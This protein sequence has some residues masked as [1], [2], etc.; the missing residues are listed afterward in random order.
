MATLVLSAVGGAIGGAI[1]GS[2]LGVS[3]AAL[4]Q[5]AGATIGRSIDQKILG[6]GSQAVE[7][8]RVDRLRLTGASEGAPI[9]QVFGRMRVAGQVIWAS[10]FTE[11][12]EE[13]SAGGKGGGPEVKTTS[14]SYSVSLA[15]ALCEGEISHVGRV[16]ADG[17]EIARESLSLSIHYGQED[18]APDPIIEAIEG[19]GTVPCYGGLAYVVLEDFSISTYGNRVPQLSFEVFRPAPEDALDLDVATSIEAV[20]LMPGTGEFAYATEPVYVTRHDGSINAVNVNTPSGAT[21][22]VTSLNGMAG[23]LP[24]CGS[25]S[26]IVSWFGNDLRCGSC[27]VQPKV[28]NPTLDVDGVDWSVAG[29]TR[30]QAGVVPVLEERPVYGGT[31][32]DHTIFGAIRHLNSLS[33]KVVFYPFLLMEQLAGNT[34]PDPYGSEE[35]PVLP[36]RGRITTA[37]APGQA[38]SPDKTAQTRA[39]VEAFFGI[40]AADDFVVAQDQVSYVGGPD[41]G[42]RRFILHYAHLCAAA[43]GVDAFCI[44]SEM[45]GLTALRDDLG[46]PAVA[47]FKQLAADVR[48]ILGPDTKIGYAADWSEYFG[49]QP[50]DGSGDRYF[51]LDPL[52]SDPNID[53]I[54]IDNYMPLSDWREGT[55]HLD[56]G[57]KSIY[58]LD[59]LKSNIEGGEGFDWFYHSEEARAAQIRTPIT[60]GAHNEPW[61]YR[62]KDMRSFWEEEHFDR[63]NGQ[64]SATPTGWVP[65]S[66]PIWFTELGCPAVDKGTNQPNKFI[67]PKSS[68]SSLPFFSNGRRDELMQAQYLKAVS[69]YWRDPANN[70]VSELYGGSMIDMTRAHVWAWDAR[71]FPFFPNAIDTWSDGENYARGHWLNGRSSGRDLGSVIKEIVISAGLGAPDTSK[72]YGFVRG[73][74]VPDA[75]TPREALQPLLTA[76]AVDAIEK[77]GILTFKSR[78]GLCDAVIDSGES[79]L[80]NNEISLARLRDNEA[81]VVGRIKLDFVEADGDYTV[82]SSEAIW[83][84]E[85]VQVVSR[86]EV[87]LSLTGGEAQAIAERWL[88]EARVAQDSV[89]ATLPPSSLQIGAGDLIRFD[90]E[91]DV[92]RIDAVEDF[93]MRRVRATRQDPESLKPSREIEVAAHVANFAVSVPM[94]AHFLDLPS[95]DGLATAPQMHVAL[96]SD[97]W[98]GQGAI[99]A[100]ANGSNLQLETVAQAR[101]VTGTLVSPLVQHCSGRLQAGSVDVRLKHGN[102]QSLEDATFLAGGNLAALGDGTASAWE[103]VQFQ[104]AEL[105]APQ[106]YRLSGLLR[107]QGGSEP[108]MAQVWPAGTEFIFL[109]DR[110]S[111][112]EISIAHL[113]LSR[114]FAWGPASETIS[115]ASFRDRDVV[116]S[117]RA[118]R[119]YAPCH[120]RVE[121]TSQGERLT[122]IRRSR[123]VGEFWDEIETPLGEQS[124]RY[125]LELSF[126]GTLVRKVDLTESSFLYDASMQ[127][128]DGVT[129]AFD[130]RV[131]QVSDIYGPGA[132][133]YKTV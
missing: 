14:Y 18:Q 1:G 47:A 131:A 15:V 128:A 68:E 118:L 53:F 103:I 133:A 114:Q 55:A 2:V 52:W 6:S 117:G 78:N 104:S 72:A 10:R 62:Y 8:G 123:V 130:F 90:D 98:P 44:G 97:P 33:Q 28:E 46:F 116:V 88:S 12:K 30:A 100:S 95:L 23:E 77:D 89:Q 105:I 65:R 101:S 63:V 110:L 121:N 93:G 34:L 31:P 42:Y 82:R 51:H 126:G 64:R 5:L 54:G 40:A 85:T 87:N 9:G 36:W 57:A 20:A 113:R 16:W 73:F 59:Y 13:S 127:A 41:Q 84:D 69:S 45:R 17:V 43:G 27:D 115:S 35:Q 19:E 48:A 120:L 96:T 109:D 75:S 37:L 102:L 86:N 39:E 3:A 108:E 94:T 7:V 81:E 80:E 112:L 83:P 50:Q 24:N 119:P 74:H 11:T 4:G 32:S 99:Y 22:F 92:F 107:G 71:P 60:D 125:T 21:D 26:L 66:K 122:W 129:G 132:W 76:Y 67:D 58:N 79:V 70:P 56:A 29:I 91:A 25:V 38:G 61:I 106:T 111:Q 124:E 49:H